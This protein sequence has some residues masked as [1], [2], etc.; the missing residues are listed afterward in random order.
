[1]IEPRLNRRQLLA[2]AIATIGYRSTSSFSKNIE[3]PQ[4]TSPEPPWPELKQAALDYLSHDWKEGSSWPFE[5]I[6][7][8]STISTGS[9]K[10]FIDYYPPMPLSFHNKRDSEDGY[11]ANYF[12]PNGS[13]A[14][15]ANVG[16]F[17]QDR[18]L[19]VGKWS[20]PYWQEIN[21]TIEILRA[22]AIGGDGFVVD[23]LRLPPGPGSE[24]VSMLYEVAANIAPDFRLMPCIDQAALKFITSRQ[25]VE[26]LTFFYNQHSVSR[27]EDSRMLVSAF[28]PES[29]PAQLWKEVIDEMAERRMPVAFLPVFLNTLDA[30]DFVPFSYGFSTWGER[31]PITVKS[32]VSAK[33]VRSLPGAS[34]VWMQPV[35]PQDVRPK[36]AAFWEC[37]GSLLFRA[38]WLEAMKRRADFVHIV[39]WND[40]SESTAIAPSIG[41][42]FVFYDL[43]AYY[44]AW[45]KLGRPP[46]V[47]ADAIYYL[48]RQQIIGADQLGAATQ[49]RLRGT[50]PISNIIEGVFFLTEAATVEIE[51]AGKVSAQ[52]SK[53]GIKCFQTQA[54]EGRPIFRIK[55]DGRTIIE[56]FSAWTISPPVSIPKAIY[57][58]GS[59]N[60][61]FVRSPT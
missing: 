36:V 40:Y 45:Y 27:L 24:P 12:K 20:S 49:Y 25:I 58:G 7:N 59:T 21:L 29:R 4:Q 53:A 16:G 44:G 34:Q 11:A 15:F 26:A 2:G 41:T 6:S 33:K 1:M 19:P 22:I 13:G 35:A 55:R 18:P 52:K 17:I 5:F 48:H 38:L 28:F 61:N 51:I 37:R 46:R 42:Q 57:V 8:S 43:T 31:D 3:Q 23:V 14:K 60:R 54:A 39:T 47:L 9:R 30:S 50:T 10:V 56:I 32:S